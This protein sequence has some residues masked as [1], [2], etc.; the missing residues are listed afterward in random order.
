MFDASAGAIKKLAKDT[1][2]IGADLPGFTAVLHTWGRQVQYH[3]HLHFI[4]PAGGLSTD[5]KK[6]LPAGNSFYLPVRALSKIFKA[7]FKTEMARQGLLHKIDP[8]SWQIAWNVNSQAVG[9]SEATLKYLA[10][11]IFRVAISDSRILAVKDRIVIFSYRK[12]GSNRSRKVT[13]DVIEFIR[14][15]LQHVLP[16]G[17]TKVRHYGFMSSNC[18]VSLARLRLLILAGMQNI[19]LCLTDLSAI[20]Q[21]PALPKPFCPACGGFLIYLFSLIPGKPCRG[22][23]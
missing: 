12:K 21:K 23:T 19:R 11:Y 20:K 15:F 10:P 9:S 4:V 6:W 17:F 8:S 14:R 2:F 22:P 1:R 18:A 5:R 16:A 3:P 7:K 13:L